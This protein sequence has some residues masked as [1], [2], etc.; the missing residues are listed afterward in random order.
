VRTKAQMLAKVRA[1]GHRHDRDWPALVE[2]EFSGPFAGT[3]FV[4]GLKFDAVPNSFA[5]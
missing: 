3:D 5:L 1:W 2:A 4:K